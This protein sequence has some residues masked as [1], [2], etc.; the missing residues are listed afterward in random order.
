LHKG[1]KKEK[2]GER[3][4]N[5]VEEVQTGWKDDLCDGEVA[6]G[7]VDVIVIIQALQ[8][9]VRKGVVRHGDT[10]QRTDNIFRPRTMMVVE[11]FGAG[12]AAESEQQHPSDQLSHSCLLHGSKNTFFSQEGRCRY[13]E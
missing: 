4:L 10:V 5:I 3:F 13:F 6:D 11:G 7:A 1:F 2:M 9:R 8:Y 12:H